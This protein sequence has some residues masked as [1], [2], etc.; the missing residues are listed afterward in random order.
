MVS[1]FGRRLGSNFPL[2]FRVSIWILFLGFVS[3][4]IVLFVFCGLTISDVLASIIGLLSAGWSLLLIG[5]ACRPLLRKVGLSDSIKGLA[6]GYDN[7]MGLIIFIPIVILSCF[8]F[9]SEF[10]KRLLFNQ[11]FSRSSDPSD[12]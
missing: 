7:V 10:Q 8:P 1:I 3:T 11:A 2:M 12:L 9:V 6:R 5:Q 4:M